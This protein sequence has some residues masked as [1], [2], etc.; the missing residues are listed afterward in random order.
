LQFTS[1]GILVSLMLQYSNSFT[2]QMQTADSFKAC[3]D[4]YNERNK[5]VVL[6]SPFVFP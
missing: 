3:G 5:D 6:F 1:S 4:D 2:T